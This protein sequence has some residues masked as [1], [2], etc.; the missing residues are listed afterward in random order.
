MTTVWQQLGGFVETAQNLGEDR[1]A[2]FADVGGRWVAPVLYGDQ[3]SGPWNLE[4]IEE[5]KQSCARHGVA[6]GGWF[7]CWAGDPLL[8]AAAIAAITLQHQLK[9]CVIDLEAA[10]QFPNGHG[11]MPKLVAELRRLLGRSWPIAVSTNGMNN[12]MIWNGRTLSPARSFYALGIRV[13]PQWYS[14]E[15]GDSNDPLDLQ[16]QPVAGDT[17][18]DKNMRWLKVFGGSDFNFRDPTARVVSYRGLPL[19]FVHGT[20]E[21]TGTEGASLA[22]ELRW[23]TASQAYGYTTGLSYYLLEAAPNFD[24][25]MALLRAVRGK[26]FLT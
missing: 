1:V 16:A 20:V 8:D 21:A 3:A 6:V 22:D 13:L 19:S 5:T 26:L 12:S 11:D 15:W 14:W 24:A 4:H 2:A 7:N 23:V 18:P 17:R 10:Y 9:P 25:D